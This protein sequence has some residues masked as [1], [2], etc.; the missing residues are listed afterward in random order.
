MSPHRLGSGQLCVLMERTSTAPLLT[1]PPPCHLQSPVATKYMLVTC[2]E[3]SCQSDWIV[4]GRPGTC[5]HGECRPLAGRS[6]LL[7]LWSL[8]LC[9]SIPHTSEM[10]SPGNIGATLVLHWGRRGSQTLENTAAPETFSIKSAD[11][12]PVCPVFHCTI[13]TGCPVRKI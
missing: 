9:R 5:C 4:Q 13:H 7:A 2:L 8:T 11:V 6:L 12:T 3:F 10:G 1:Q